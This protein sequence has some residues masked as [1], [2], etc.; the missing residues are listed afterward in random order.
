MAYNHFLSLTG[1]ICADILIII[2][3][4]FLTPWATVLCVIAAI[5]YFKNFYEAIAAGVLLDMLYGVALVKFFHTPWAMTFLF[6]L[7]YFIFDY[8]KRYTRFYGPTS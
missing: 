8:A 6:L 3:I 4:F 7:I 5:L 2:S 1:R